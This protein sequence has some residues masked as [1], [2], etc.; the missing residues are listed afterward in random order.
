MDDYPSNLRC[1]LVCV[2]FTGLDQMVALEV[3]QSMLTQIITLV[4]IHIY[5]YFQWI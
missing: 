5:W 4:L 1:Q 2:H 3:C